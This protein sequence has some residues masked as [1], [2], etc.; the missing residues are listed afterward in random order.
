[1]Y[2]LKEK[3]EGIVND[4]KKVLNY[5]FKSKTDLNLFY[6]NK[7]SNLLKKHNN[8]FIDNKNGIKY[9]FEIIN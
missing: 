2:V 4:Y 7:V 6:K 5:V 1:M 8:I 9:T 3:Q